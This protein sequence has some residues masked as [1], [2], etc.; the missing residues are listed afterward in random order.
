[1]I[2]DDVNCAIYQVGTFKRMFWGTLVASFL[3]SVA[4]Y[5]LVPYV[6]KQS[7]ESV[8]EYAIL[9][10]IIACMFSCIPVYF[11]WNNARKHLVEVKRAECIAELE[12]KAS[13]S[14]DD[15]GPDMTGIK[16][17]IFTTKLYMGFDILLIAT[18]MG[19][20]WLAIHR[21]NSGE[22]PTL[23]YFKI[24]GMTVVFSVFIWRLF[25]DRETFVRIGVLK[26]MTEYMAQQEGNHKP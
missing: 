9:L 11:L 15:Y 1:M 4:I 16:Q 24:G 19:G 22:N 8:P 26:L 2:N 6:A 3:C 23:N 10:G 7:G 17:Q 12:G 21:I 25:R 13:P 5:F 18:S 14:S 20:T